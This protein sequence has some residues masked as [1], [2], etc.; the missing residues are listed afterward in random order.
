M[1]QKESLKSI[2]SSQ[3][4]ISQRVQVTYTLVKNICQ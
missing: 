3:S 4:G 2:N 1:E